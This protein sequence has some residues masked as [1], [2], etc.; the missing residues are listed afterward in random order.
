MK[1][2][3]DDR[4]FMRD[5]KN[6]TQYA[7]GFIDGAQMGKQDLMKNLGIEVKELL[8]QYID[9]NAS[10][11]PSR[12]QHVYEWMQSG[13]PD[14]RLYDL[15]YIV[16]GAGLSF[17]YTLS[18][19]K[20]IKDG[21]KVPFY[22]KA[23]IMENGVP[24][25]IKAKNAQVLSFNDNGEQVFTA[26]PIRVNSPGGEN[27]RGGLDATIKEFFSR[28]LSQA[29]LDVS[30]IGFNLRNPVDFKNNIAAGKRGGRPVGVRVGKEWIS[31]SIT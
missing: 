21:S 2:E 25:T 1:L 6:L 18:Q 19:S 12:L 24:V 8:Y 26:K 9:S 27:A 23:S 5:M 15:D 29:F 3:L 17:S 28:Y 13:S 22:N 16:T 4:K 20:S 31:R 11:D 7:L 10:I 14:A 30:G